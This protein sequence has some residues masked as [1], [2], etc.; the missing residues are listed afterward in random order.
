MQLQIF[1]YNSEEQQMFDEI[2]TIDQ[3]DGKILFCATDVAKMLGYSNPRDAVSKH[4]KYVVKCDIPHPQNNEK[5]LEVGFMPEGD[6][7]RLIVRSQLPSAEKFEK[8]LFD[9]V[10]PAIRNK[11]FYGKIDRTALPN[12]IERY[13]DNYYKLPNNYFSVIS[14][15]YARLYM[16]LEK[17]GYSVPDRG[18][19]GKQ[20]MP[21]ISVGRLFA[22][23]LKENN[24]E[25]FENHR[26]YK[27]TFPD[28]REVDAN[29]YHIDALPIFIRYINEKWIPE[30]AEKYFKDKDPLALYYLPKVLQQ[31]N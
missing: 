24:S 5:T 19:H 18:E 1:K 13:K 6:V 23:Y 31:R 21:D 14:E 20:M 10:V 15:M 11:G 8:W 29:M 7:Y 27:H 16:E 9:E 25:F 30:N 22:K 4:C 3:E 28:G 17:V 26:T 12:F 2:R